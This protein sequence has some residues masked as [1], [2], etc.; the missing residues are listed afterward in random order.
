VLNKF[1]EFAYDQD[2]DELLLDLPF[3]GPCEMENNG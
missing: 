2:E 1:G 3:F